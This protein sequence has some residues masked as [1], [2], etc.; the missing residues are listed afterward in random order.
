MGN[1]RLFKFKLNNRRSMNS[2]ILCLGIFIPVLTACQLI[3][4][5]FVDYNGVRRDV[6]EWI[7]QQTFLSMQ[8]KRS[9]A[10]LSKAQ[11]KLVRIEMIKES[12]KLTVAKENAI[13][14]HCAHLHASEQKI[15]QLQDQIFEAERK[16]TILKIFDEQFPKVKLDSTSI[17]CE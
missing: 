2:K 4:P 6:A 15:Q 17:Q 11:Q 14:L 16:A 10:Q 7:N 3:S 9:L 12:D 1:Y 5:I 8:Q 13:A